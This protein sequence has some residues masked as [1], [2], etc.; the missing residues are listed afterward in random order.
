MLKFTLHLTTALTAM[1]VHGVALAQ[2]D[3]SG[4]EPADTTSA[5]TTQGIADIVVT[6]QRRSENLQRAALAISAVTGDSLAQ[7]GIANV[8]GLTTVVPSL[9]VGASGPYNLFYLRGVGTFTVNP[10]SDSTVSFN[11]DGIAISRPSATSGV[12]Y[13]I[14]RVEVLKGPQGTLYGRNATGGAINVIT[15]E[16]E[17]NE[18]GG[19]FSGEYGN[20]DRVKLNGAL[21]VPLGDNAALRVAATSIDH[22]PYLSDGTDDQKDRAGR[23]RFKL[24]A[25]PDIT[26]QLGA[27]YFHQ[28]GTGTGAVLIRENFVED[29]IGNT[30]PRAQAIYASTLYFPAGSFLPPLP[31]DVNSNNHFWGVNGSLEWR[32]DLGTLTVLPAFRRNTI[33]FRSA[34]S[35][36]HIIE[37]SVSEQT[38][39]EARFA[40]DDSRPLSWLVGGYYLNETSDVEGSFNNGFNIS[41]QA[42]QAPLESLAAFGRLTYAVT[43]RF[44]ISGGVR[45]TRDRK[46]I[47][48][49]GLNATILCFEALGTGNPFACLG[50]PGFPFT[51][52][53]P[54][55]ALLAA[56]TG[57]PIPY[58]PSGAIIE[59]QPIIQDQQRTFKKTTWR[60]GVEFDVAP[61]SLLYAS[62]ET[63]FK[64]GGFY[65]GNFSPFY[66]PETITAYTVGSKNRFFNNSLQLNAE[67]FYWKYKDQQVSSITRDQSGA[68]VFATQNVGRATVKGV[69]IEAVYSPVRSTVLGI[70]VQYLDAEYDSFVYSVPNLGGPPTT[71][72]PFT[73]VG[74]NQVIDCSGRPAPQ[75]PK[76]SINLNAEQ[77][78]PLGSAGELVFNAATK[79]QSA[80]WLSFEYL[81][82]QRQDSYWMSNAQVTFNP[83]SERWWI[84]GFI[85]N[86]EDTTVKTIAFP[87]PQAGAA[88][89]SSPLRAPRTYGVRA[90]VRF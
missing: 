41:N 68:V 59:A 52:V 30:D 79:Y 62:V 50:T 10:L 84:S 16:P 12:F 45:Y 9:Q 81:S 17:L 65:V 13:D 90:G 3:A 2:T 51:G 14:E 22:D 27:D 54:A 88:L 5:E 77:T 76:W 73:N 36:L 56:A 74:P 19:E 23:L 29:R 67:A 11:V 87:H 44:R 21:N 33:D 42:Y 39:F 66:R 78:I 40:S 28:G 89:V 6:A 48:N 72:C 64:A 20:Y 60:A 37:N 85:N 61:R 69:E 57:A 26:I 58:G 49:N 7:T 31:N 32:S 35:G 46:E 71:S 8:E 34:A 1:M 63:G 15:R 55:E 80:V 18:L 25:T 70:N 38:S 43:D 24:E 53:A 83:A 47:E 75:S 86:I 82:S 4:P